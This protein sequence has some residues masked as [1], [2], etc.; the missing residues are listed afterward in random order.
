M[1][2][3][4]VICSAILRGAAISGWSPVLAGT[5]VIEGAAILSGST[6][7]AEVLRVVAAA[8]R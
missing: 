4:A 3:S 8:I 6:V 1:L 7:A 5:A 2:P